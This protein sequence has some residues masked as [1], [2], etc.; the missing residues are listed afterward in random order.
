VSS[1]A[2]FRDDASSF[3]SFRDEASSFVSFRY[4]EKFVP[5]IPH[6]THFRFRFRRIGVVR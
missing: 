2:S 4:N 3:A 1:F 6:E 5:E